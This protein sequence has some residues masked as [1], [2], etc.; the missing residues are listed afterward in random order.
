MTNLPQ[1]LDDSGN[2][3]LLSCL[4]YNLEN[5]AAQHAKV[6]RGKRER[7]VIIIEGKRYQYAGGHSINK[8]LA[9]K[10][11]A[12]YISMSHKTSSETTN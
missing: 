1:E 2:P 10:I 4:N 7:Y 5:G 11:I 3:S 8:N 6:K 9:K 12:L